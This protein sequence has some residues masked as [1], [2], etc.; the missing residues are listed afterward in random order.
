MLEWVG[1]LEQEWESANSG[2]R[3]DAYPQKSLVCHPQQFNLNARTHVR[4]AGSQL[5]L[6]A[7]EK[8]TTGN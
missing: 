5:M 8:P 2:E 6:K 4:E 3:S 7:P 1:V